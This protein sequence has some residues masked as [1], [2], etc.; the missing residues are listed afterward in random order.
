MART[1]RGLKEYGI[2]TVT[3]DLTSIGT[4]SINEW[5]LGLL[6]RIKNELRLAIDTVAWWREH[7]YLTP[8]Q[9][10]TDFLRNV[11]LTE[12]SDKV[13]IFVDEIDTTLTLDFRDDFF[14]TIRAMY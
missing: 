7:S 6:S 14:A 12:I 4:V 8:P 9:R 3:V 5:F 2:K 11:V 13:A 1:T 10:F